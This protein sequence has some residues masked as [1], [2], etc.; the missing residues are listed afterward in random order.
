MKLVCFACIGEINSI[1]GNANPGYV[2]GLGRNALFAG[3]TAIAVDSLGTIYVCDSF[4]SAI[5][6]ITPS[7]HD[8]YYVTTLAGGRN[9]SGYADGIG[10]SAL[11]RYPR[12]IAVDS[13]GVLF[14]S[15]YENNVIRKILPS[16]TV[17][18]LTVVHNFLDSLSLC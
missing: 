4:N 2:D 15:D 14:V 11:F 13:N 5:R 7:V 17:L 12:G 9:G 6:V 16:G 1:A 10:M 8:Q 3:P 18:Y